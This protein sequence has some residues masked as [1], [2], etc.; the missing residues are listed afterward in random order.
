M[1]ICALVILFFGTIA[2]GPAGLEWR[3]ARRARADFPTVKVTYLP[4]RSCR[5]D[6]P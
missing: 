1:I 4:S 5:A 2:T 6:E 3:D